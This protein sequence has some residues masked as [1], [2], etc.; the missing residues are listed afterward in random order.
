[1]RWTEVV[2]LPLTGGDG[3]AAGVLERWSSPGR[4]TRAVLG[5]GPDG[6]F[7][8]DL[9]RDG[10]HALVAGTTGSGK[11]ELLQTLIASLALANRPD[12]LT[13]VLVDY[14]GGAA[15][16]PC[17]R[18]PHTVGLV[19]DLDGSLV[20]RALASLSAELSRREAV[21][22][23][24]G[25]KDVEEHRRRVGGGAP[26]PRLVIVVDEFASLAEELPDFVGG[27]VG[28]A[29]RGRSLG[30]HLVLA[31]Q[32]PEGVVSPDIRANTN[33]RL[34]LAV[35]RETES[36]DVLDAPV[37]ARI[38]RTTPGRAWARTG[39]AELTP[40]QAGR[41]GGRRPSVVRRDA[42]PS[43]EVLP[44]ADLGAP[45]PRR[46]G[47]SGQEAADEPVTD[48][49]LLVDACVAAAE[50]LGLPRQRSPWLPPLP[51]RLVLADLPAVPDPQAGRPGRVPA[52]AVRRAGR[53]GRAGAAGAGARPRPDLA[54]D[55]RG[56]GPLG[57]H[58]GPAHAGR[59]AGRRH[60]PR[61]RAPLRARPR[62]QR[63][64]P[65]GGAPAHRCGRGPGRPR[66]AG[67]GARAA[68]R[69]VGRRQGVLAAGGHA[70]LAEQR[71]AAAPA[72][73]LPHL[74]LLLDRWE[75]FLS[76]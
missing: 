69:E 8:V 75:A 7:S 30:V 13:F 9:S 47:P 1:V 53:A 72:D 70:D 12:E 23:A 27:L 18:L 20:E 36:R 62:R 64:R 58:H 52:V 14:K 48:L 54:P 71:A 46:T 60:L 40:F 65:A 43:V 24:V 74:V 55:G 15:F 34:C 39:H 3:D 33:L 59:C 76:A 10:P 16:G 50:Q 21:L 6:V 68:G 61:R 42:A 5:R 31:T 4:S 63:P 25:A 56:L 28:I 37:A 35:A 41:V 38:S 73:R 49:S 22:Q 29:M 26:L 66:P 45:L 11:S 44:P 32:R 19:T 2:S 51:H 17:A 67:P 57:A